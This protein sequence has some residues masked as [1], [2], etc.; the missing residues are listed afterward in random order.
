MD[1]GWKSLTYCRAVDCMGFAGG[2]AVLEYPEVAV[3]DI[4]EVGKLE[5]GHTV[6]QFQQ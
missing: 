1:F 4:P 6:V 5:I 3:E 2:T